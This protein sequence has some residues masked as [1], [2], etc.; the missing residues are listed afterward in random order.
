MDRKSYLLYL[1]II[2]VC[3]P[4]RAETVL[5]LFKQ[6]EEKNPEFKISG[7]ERAIAKEGKSQAKS[8]LMPQVT[9]E[10][11]AVENWQ[12]DNWWSGESTENT[13]LG[14]NVSLA[15]PLYRRG[16]NATVQQA[17]TGIQQANVAYESA[18][19]NLMASILQGYFNVLA[20]K[21]KL[22]NAQANK[23]AIV[24]Q[25]EQVKAKFEVG[26]IAI[27]DVQEAQAAYDLAI[28]DEIQAKN[29]VDN[30][31]EA[32]REII[33]EYPQKIAVL[34]SDIPLVNPD[35]ENSEEWVEIALKQNP[36]IIVAQHAVTKARQ[37]IKK[38]RVNRY[39]TVDLV[40]Q[41][42]YNDSVRGDD[43]LGNATGNT[44]GI[45]FSYP[46]FEG[47]LRSSRVREARQRYSQALDRLEQQQRV[48]QQQTRNAYLKVMSSISRVK[49]FQQAVTSTE[50]AQKAVEESV[51]A[52]L[53]TIV[54]LLNVTSNVYQAKTNLAQARYDY[55]V[56][57]FL[58]KQAAGMLSTEDLNALNEWL[59][60]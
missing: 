53:R 52:E 44:V 55:V 37:E 2:L 15:Y 8:S 60:D 49:A 45:Q 51:D 17:E 25:L 5:D 40:A 43:M 3:S 12:L 29:E 31:L 10:A 21:D 23:R 38:Q 35:P 14:Y 11:S 16:L 48:V 13:T 50:T 39:P 4:L 58:L 36:S 57:T 19:Q 56:S 20:G 26:L 28:A 46:L 32:L 18:K 27:T 34:K 54:D 41:H 1:L 30:A 24:G 33:G 9:L 22:S 6:A 7:T 59:K 42:R 47:G